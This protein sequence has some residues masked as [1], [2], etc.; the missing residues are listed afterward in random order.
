LPWWP[1][2]YIKI[3]FVLTG[4]VTTVPFDAHTASHVRRAGFGVTSFSFKKEVTKK[5][6]P[7]VPSGAS[8]SV[9]HCMDK[10]EI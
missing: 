7:D 1:P 4:F 3:G 10:D 6:N 2:V 9:P 5:V 8:L